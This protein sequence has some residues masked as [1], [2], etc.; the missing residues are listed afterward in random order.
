MWCR[1]SFSFA[2]LL[3]LVAVSLPTGCRRVVVAE[4][5][6]GY[7]SGDWGDMILEREGDGTIVGAYSHDEGLLAGSFAEEVFTG[8]WCEVPSRQPDSDAGDVEFNFTY[9][10]DVLALD[11]R[12]RY[13]SEQTM[14]EDWDVTLQSG[15]GPAELQA[16]LDAGEGCP[17]PQ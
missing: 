8:W 7:W 1:C 15:A 4:D 6:V 2:V 16:R 13:G 17:D 9:Q 10:G 11:G 12:W 3:S 5:I 14:R